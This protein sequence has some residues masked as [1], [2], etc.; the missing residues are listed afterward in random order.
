MHRLLAFGAPE[1]VLERE[2]WVPRDMDTVFDFFS[3]AR[4]LKDIT[5][6]W[7][8]FQIIS[9]NPPEMQAGTRIWYRLKWNGVPYKWQTLIE[10][11]VPNERFVDT[12]KNGPYILWHHTHTFERVQGGILVRDRVRYRLPFGPLGV[13]L[14]TLIVRRQ[15]A[16][17]FDYRVQVIAER[18]ADGITYTAPPSLQKG[19]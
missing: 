17:I 16:E 12:M 19:A 6:R 7:L 2:Q 15:L 4:N 14:H 11:W 18:L 13:L 8:H 1:Y 3:D 5:P 10:Q 9:V